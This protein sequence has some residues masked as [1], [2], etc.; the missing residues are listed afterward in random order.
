MFICD[1]ANR[2]L[3]GLIH[4]VLAALI[5]LSSTGMVLQMHYC[6]D[7]LQSV[8]LFFK[9]EHCHPVKKASCPFHAKQEQQKSCCTEESGFAK[10][11][12]Q[13][14]PLLAD[15]GAALDWLIVYPIETKTDGFFSDI[16]F[17]HYLNYKPPLLCPD[18][19]I[20]VQSFRI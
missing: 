17:P 18:I 15:A 11:T 16:F 8:S 14:I 4:I 12:I 13:Q 1:I 5:F 7:E 2:M 20:A 10:L 3:R 9:A 6:M 19:P